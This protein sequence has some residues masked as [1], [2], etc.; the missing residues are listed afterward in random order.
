MKKTLILLALAFSTAA[1]ASE[2]VS[3]FD[4]QVHLSKVFKVNNID[5]AH[6]HNFSLDTKSKVIKL[7]P[8]ASQSSLKLSLQQICHECHRS[9]EPKY[10][11]APK[12]CFACHKT[13]EGIQQIKPMNHNS[14]AWKTSHT[15]EARVSGE[16]C[17]NCHM[18]SQCAKCHLQ[19]S[20]ISNQNHPRNFRFFHSVQARGQP[21]RCDACHTKS[22]CTNC[23]L[24][25]K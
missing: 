2:M 7:T 13:M 24:G 20:D 17:T 15:L 6:C 21:Q 5:C 23:H 11:E 22:Y 3:N 1:L 19:R 12:A 14:L 8:E 25:K 16:S 18:T 4:H 9:E 10:K